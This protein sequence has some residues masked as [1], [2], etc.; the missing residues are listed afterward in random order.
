MRTGSHRFL[1]A[2][3]AALL[4]GS[5]LGSTAARAAGEPDQ[6]GFPSWEERVHHQLANRARVDPQLEMTACGAPCDEAACYTPQGPLHYNPLLGRAA[7]FHAAHMS[8]NGYFAHASSCTLVSSLPTTY[9]NQ[10]DGAASCSCEG[11]V[12]QCSGTCTSAQGRVS[13][14]GAGY[15]GE[16]IAS[17]GSPNF[18]FYLWLYEDAG[19]DSQCH[20]TMANG[21]RWL[22]LTNSGGVGFG[23][24]GLHVG[25]FGSSDP[26]WVHPIPSGTHWP[27]QSATVE[28]WAN[29]YDSS[30]P[31]SALLN[32]DGTCQPMTLE[33]GTA[34]NG[35]YRADVTGVGSGC[36]RYYFVFADSTNTPVT[37]PST[38]SLGIGPQGT[39]DDWNTERPA[40]G[41][42]CDCAPSCGGN[43]CGDD[44]CGGS[45]GDCGANENCVNGQCEGSVG[46]D[47]GPGPDG[48][49]TEDS[50]VPS[51][52]ASGVNPPGDASG[53]CNCR[54]SGTAGGQSAGLVLLTVLLWIR[55]R[56]V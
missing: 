45:C 42:G 36:H 19:G 18:A 13:M 16:I 1:C 51:I 47:A 14:W 50:A 33:R 10:C 29:W 54:S 48:T 2:F 39:C 38:G 56:N 37:F 17:G 31:L 12:N 23:V 7:R 5:W 3:C 46:P 15:G 40:L 43:V 28:V 32:V 35:A 4:L 30:A 53:G 8:L 6:D 34:T 27:R 52:D 9:P 41:A 49:A 11:G 22:L 25:D 44:G 55:R 20:F 24:D 26:S 21:H